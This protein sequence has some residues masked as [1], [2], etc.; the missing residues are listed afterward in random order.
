M[1]SRAKNSHHRSKAA[2]AR[3]NAVLLCIGVLLLMALVAGFIWLISSPD[4]LHRQ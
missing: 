3:R 1:Q 4:L 2:K